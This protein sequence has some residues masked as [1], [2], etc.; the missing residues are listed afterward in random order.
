MTDNEL[1]DLLTE[2]AQ[3]DG[4][5]G[6][7]MS[8]HPAA[9]AADE[10]RMLYQFRDEACGQLIDKLANLIA[11]SQLSLPSGIHLTALKESM[12]E[13]QEEL[14]VAYFEAGGDDVWRHGG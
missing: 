12:P 2:L 5:V 1:I 11:S 4:V 3:K 10:L 9:L 14:K 13:M 6:T 7:D 8:I